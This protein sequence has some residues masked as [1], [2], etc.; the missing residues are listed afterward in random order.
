MKQ[1]S[2]RREVRKEVSGLLFKDDLQSVIE[3][4][5]WRNSN[6]IA[7]LCIINNLH[8]I[9]WKINSWFPSCLINVDHLS[10]ST[11][12][13]LFVFFFSF[14]FAHLFVPQLRNSLKNDVCLDQGPDNDNT[15]ILYLCHG[16]TPQVRGAIAL[17]LSIRSPVDGS[18]VHP[19]LI[20]HLCDL[21]AGGVSRHKP[22]FVSYISSFL[23][24]RIGS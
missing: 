23:Q 1:S 2:K 3:L 7:G 24:L 5:W 22:C 17:R 21:F 6:N 9:I 15:P 4:P 13:L 19:S 18:G 11:S 12:Q 16:L 14:C 10:S 20:H 8:S